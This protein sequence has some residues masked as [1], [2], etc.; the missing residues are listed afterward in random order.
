[1]ATYRMVYGDG[2]QVARETFADVTVEQEDG[3]T[4]LFRGPRRDPAG[5]RRARAVPGAGGPAADPGARPDA[6]AGRQRRAGRPSRRAAYL[7]K[8]AGDSALVV[9][10]D[11]ADLKPVAVITDTTSPPRSRTARIQRR[12]DQRPAGAAADHGAADETAAAGGQPHGGLPHPPP[13]VVD[14]GRL[15]GNGRHR[16]RLPRPDDEL[17]VTGPRGAGRRREPADGTPANRA[18]PAPLGAALGMLPGIMRGAVP[19][20]AEWCGGT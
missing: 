10:E 8:K 18:F 1:M 16:R 19:A 17:T 6:A 20:P 13:P 9:V 2:E 15:V 5:A 11:E 14:D 3:W 4:V 7:M 12:A